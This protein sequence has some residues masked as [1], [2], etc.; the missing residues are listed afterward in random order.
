M[1]S[2]NE[3]QTLRKHSI[4]IKCKVSQLEFTYPISTGQMIEKSVTSFQS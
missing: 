1:V 4:F 3:S 2:Q